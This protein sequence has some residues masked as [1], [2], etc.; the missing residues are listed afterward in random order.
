MT[1]RTSLL[2]GHGLQGETNEEE[3]IDTEPEVMSKPPA[4][5][6]DGGSDSGDGLL[7][8]GAHSLSRTGLPSAPGVGE[9]M[10]QPGLLP[11]QDPTA[12]LPKPEPGAPGPGEANECCRS[13][14]PIALMA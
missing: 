7:P 10:A 13:S 14:G 3:D 9:T 8:S 5:S 12:G 6:K 1:S 11:A 2:G 4:L